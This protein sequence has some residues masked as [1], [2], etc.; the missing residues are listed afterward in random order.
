MNKMTM[1]SPR[2]P[3]TVCAPKFI[4]LVIGALISFASAVSIIFPPL[5]F[6]F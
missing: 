1:H 4:V 5:Y 3:F 6:L 2:H